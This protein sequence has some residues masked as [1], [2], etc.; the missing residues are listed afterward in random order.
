MRPISN[1]TLLFFVLA[2]IAFSV[3]GTLATL[4]KLDGAKAAAPTGMA[5]AST[6]GVPT[7]TASASLVVPE[8]APKR[9]PPVL[10]ETLV[11]LAS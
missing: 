7:A 3:F 2:M 9:A 10:E 1:I 4:Q 5:V 8:P 11:P 6:S